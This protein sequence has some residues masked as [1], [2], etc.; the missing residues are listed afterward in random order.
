MII[1]IS[2]LTVN[3]NVY[4]RRSNVT[5]NIL[6]E[7]SVI[8][9]IDSRYITKYDSTTIWWWWYISCR[10]NFNTIFV[11]YEYWRRV[12]INLTIKSVSTIF[13]NR[14]TRRS[15]CQYNTGFNWN[16]KYNSLLLTANAHRI[17]GKPLYTKIYDLLGYCRIKIA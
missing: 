13:Y 15:S 11:P 7:T 5:N 17:Y 8:S 12:C 10:I 16:N 2:K 3:D 1:N 4:R 14:L 6:T 9:G